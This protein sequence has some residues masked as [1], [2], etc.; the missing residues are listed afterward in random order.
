MNS[1]EEQHFGDDDDGVWCDCESD[2]TWSIPPTAAFHPGQDDPIDSKDAEADE[3]GFVGLAA[4][5]EKFFAQKKCEVE[6]DESLK[7]VTD[8]V[9]GDGVHAQYAQGIG[10][11]G[12]TG[13]ICHE[14][15]EG[16]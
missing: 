5:P 4:K 12:E 6:A 7:Q 10:P 2:W 14:E 15:E 3:K 8:E 1:M 9:G 13:G 11:E 16:E